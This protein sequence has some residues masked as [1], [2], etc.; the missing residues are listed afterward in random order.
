MVSAFVD[1]GYTRKSKIIGEE[2]LYPDVIFTWRPTTNKLRVRYNNFIGATKNK[3]Q[4]EMRGA[5]CLAK[6]ILEWD[7]IGKDGNVAP[8][9]GKTLI[10]LHP[11]LFNKLFEIVIRMGKAPD[12]DLDGDWLGA[13]LDAEV[14]DVPMEDY[15]TK[16]L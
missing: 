1:D 16:N 11:E 8:I 12:E 9:D 4:Q 15:L 2:R 10:Q 3:E 7:V 13:E 14:A 6:H 5:E